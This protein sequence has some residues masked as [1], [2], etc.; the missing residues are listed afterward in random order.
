[1]ERPG[2][3]AFLIRARRQHFPLLPLGHPWRADLG[4]QTDVQLVGK[5][6][7]HARPQLLKS[8][9]NPRQFLDSL[10][11]VILGAQLG[12]L[13]HPAQFMQPPAHRLARHHDPAPGLEF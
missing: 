13:P 9:T 2:P 11:I 7:R 12:P 1:M 6:Q 5:E 3:V 4:H 8:I 10:G